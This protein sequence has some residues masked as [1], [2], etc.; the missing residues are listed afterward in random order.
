MKA[1]ICLLYT[2]YASVIHDFHRRHRD[3]CCRFGFRH[4]MRMGS[5]WGANLYVWYFGRVYFQTL[6]ATLANNLLLF[7]GL[8]LMGGHVRD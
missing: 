8:G 6:P 2:Y 1:L 3:R 5:A 4:G 7:S